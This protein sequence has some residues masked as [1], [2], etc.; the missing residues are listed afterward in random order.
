MNLD[1]K[2]IHVLF[3]ITKNC[4]QRKFVEVLPNMLS[5]IR[6]VFAGLILWFLLIEVFNISLYLFIA[7]ALTDLMD[8]ALARKLGTDSRT[9]AY[10]DVS[11]DFILVFLTSL[12]LILIK[13]FPVWL[14]ILEGLMFGQF[15]LTS[16]KILVYDPFGKH[17]GTLLMV[18]I[19]VTLWIPNSFM[20]PAILWIL[21]GFT[22]VC[23]ACRIITHKRL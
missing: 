3:C 17:Y 7:A 13:V 15:I 5:G 18:A 12:G 23:I 4:N 11:A 8:G 21:V 16:G 19:S 1:E 6:I 10:I 2:V 14:L 9:G 20:I 22:M